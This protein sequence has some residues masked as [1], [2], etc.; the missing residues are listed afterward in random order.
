[1]KSLLSKLRAK[2]EIQ[3]QTIDSLVNTISKN[4]GGQKKLKNTDFFKKK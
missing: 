2:T 1:M 4:E 3:N